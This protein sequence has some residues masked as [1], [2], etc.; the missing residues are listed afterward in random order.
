MAILLSGCGGGELKPQVTALKVA[1]LQYGRVATIYVGGA[2]LRN[3]MQVDTGGACTAPSFASASTPDTAVLNCKVAQVG[4]FVLSLKTA[5]G[6]ALFSTTLTVPKPQ[7][8]LSTT[9]GSITM[10][11]D[12][13]NAPVTVNNFLTYVSSA[14]YVKTLFHRVIPGFVVQAGG[15]TA[16]LVKKAGQLPPIV[17]ETKKDGLSNLRGTVAMARTPDPNSATSEF[18]VNLVDN[19]FLDF[20]STGNPGYAVFGKLVQGMDVIDTIATQ[21]TGSVGGFSNVPLTDITIN[22]ALQIQ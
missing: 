7:V 2:D 1:S 21:A 22:L 8:L 17:L 10:E 3:T 11:L 18:Y 4:D 14:Y 19:T 15:Y 12:P 5:Q 13:A 16:G 9:S 6:E 20:Q